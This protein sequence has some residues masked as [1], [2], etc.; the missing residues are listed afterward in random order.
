MGAYK[1]KFLDSV[2][3]KTRHK[4]SE[5]TID[6]LVDNQTLSKEFIQENIKEFLKEDLLEEE[7]EE[8]SLLKYLEFFKTDMLLTFTDVDMGSQI[9]NMSTNYGKIN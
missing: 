3:S 8:S 7:E 5:I 2:K 1:S 6:E 9:P 4:L